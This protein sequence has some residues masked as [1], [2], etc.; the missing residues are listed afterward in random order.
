ME[1][2]EG[3]GDEER[4]GGSREYIFFFFAVP[5]ECD[6]S[7]RDRRRLQETETVTHPPVSRCSS[8]S[9]DGCWR[10][11]SPINAFAVSYQGAAQA[12]ERIYK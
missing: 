9:K 6:V 4:G 10:F 11:M 7:L 3:D 1:E 8:S 12:P 5:V 2:I